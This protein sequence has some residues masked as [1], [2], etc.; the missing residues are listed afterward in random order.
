MANFSLQ[1]RPLFFGD[2]SVLIP[3]V[4]IGVSN[5]QDITTGKTGPNQ[6]IQDHEESG[7]LQNGLLGPLDFGW[8]DSNVDLLQFLTGEEVAPL[9]ATNQVI[10]NFTVADVDTVTSSISEADSAIAVEILKS[11]AEDTTKM[12]DSGN[13]PAINESY[14]QDSVGVDWLDVLS[15]EVSQA[16]TD[17]V[18]TEAR[19]AV[20]SPVTP[21]DVESVL[22]SGSPSPSQ[23]MDNNSSW[24]SVFSI[25]N[26]ETTN[27]PDSSVHSSIFDE[28]S[29]SDLECLL[30]QVRPEPHN[31]D[32]DY[33]AVSS[34]PS[35]GPSDSRVKP[36][37]RKNN[38]RSNK[39]SSREVKTADRHERKR[40]Q[41]KDAAL[42]Y[43]QKKKKEADI[44]TAEVD[45]LEARNTELKD[46]V[47]QMKIEIKYLK[48]L[49]GDVIK[50]KEYLKSQ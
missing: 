17:H 35:P 38:S 15:D 37:S 46:R 3:D 20:L 8:M 39:A 40:Q 47:E 45:I 44:I 24:V 41:N 14:S 50:V 13:D 30:V 33:L 6:L 1:E 36:Y 11:V 23:E 2:L 10:N 42:R 31:L 19:D 7:S 49:L 32:H 18:M 25:E 28:V 29:K 21:E 22:S 4:E 26:M 9:E 48:N 34:P 5:G 12:L 27:S 16:F 43:R